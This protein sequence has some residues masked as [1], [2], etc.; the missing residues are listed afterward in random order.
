MKNLLTIDFITHYGLTTPSLTN[1]LVE[2]NRSYFELDD[3][4]GVIVLSTSANS[5]AARIRN[6]KNLALII[7]NYERFINALPSAFQSGKK[8]CDFVLADDGN[9]CFVL[10]EIKD[11]S[12]D[13][14]EHVKRHTIRK[15]AKKQLLAS[16][17]ALVAVPSIKLSIHTKSL[18]QCAYFNKQPLAPSSL[19]VITAFNPLTSLFPAGIK[20]DSPAMEVFGF[21]FYQYTGAQ[22][23]ILK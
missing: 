17:E 18:K 1:W 14:E 22:T 5:G 13:E 6:S 10:G 21:E 16:L 19:S 20:K 23:L 3:N 15:G 9:S 12:T 8:R 4:S 2:T 11:I 7:A